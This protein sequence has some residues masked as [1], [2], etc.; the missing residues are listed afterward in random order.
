MRLAL[1][2]W[3]SLSIGTLL[4]LLCAG[5][6]ADTMTSPEYALKAAFIYNFAMFTT[7]SERRDKTI[8]LCVL[9]PDPF[10]AAI[11]PLDGKQIG[12]AKLA[13]RRINSGELL[14]S[15]QIVFVT[16]SVLDDYIGQSADVRGAAGML[17]IA[18]S[19]GAA[20]RGIM[21]ELTVEDRKIGFEF[22]RSAAQLAHVQ[23]SSKLLRIARKVY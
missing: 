17:T 8:T 19:A 2:S 7:W 16:E 5:A 1:Q 12:D 13:I 22:N 18:D 11:D 14:Q 4:A 20:R 23:V 6:G 10:G 15:C 9:G 3:C 21:I